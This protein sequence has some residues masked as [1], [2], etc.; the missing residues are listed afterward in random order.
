MTPK[1]CTACGRLLKK[2]PGPVGPVCMRKQTN[3][4][5]RGRVSKKCYIKYMKA[6]DIF[7]EEHCGQRT[8]AEASSDTK[9]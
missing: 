3:R 6:H 4:S 8:D 5:P 9:K 1:Y 7:A 2:S